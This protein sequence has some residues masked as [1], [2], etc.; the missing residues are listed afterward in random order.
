MKLSEWLRQTNAIRHFGDNGATGVSDTPQIGVWRVDLWHLSDYVVTSVS[1][2]VVWLAPR[3][4][5]GEGDF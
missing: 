1:G 5:A 2:G 4:Q 3:R